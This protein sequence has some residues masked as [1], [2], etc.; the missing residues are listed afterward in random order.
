MPG[1]GGGQPDG[2]A[3]RSGARGASGDVAPRPGV[4]HDAFQPVGRRQPRRPGRADG[5]RRPE[6]GGRSGGR[7]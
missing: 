7:T 4:R 3:S 6:R 5:G 1:D 2:W